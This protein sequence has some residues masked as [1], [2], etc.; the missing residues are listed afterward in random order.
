MKNSSLRFDRRWA[1]LGLL[2]LGAGLSYWQVWAGTGLILAAAVLLMW[3]GQTDTPELR[4]LDTLI[5][6]ISQGKLNH[7]LPRE[8]SDPLLESMRRNL[9]S[10]LDQTETAFREILGGM[11]AG[12]NHKSW[13]RLQTSGL[14]GIFVRVLTQMQGMLDD[15][16]QAQVSVAREALLS[17]IFVRSENGL[18]LA[19]RQVSSTLGEVSNQAS[20]SG[21][22]AN[23]FSSAALTMSS[24]AE[25]MSVALG[26]AESSAN[27]G[28]VAVT[29]LSE[30][31]EA[32]RRLTGN[33]DNIAKQTNLLALNASIEAARAGES[34]RGFAVVA[35]E[36]RKLADESQRSAEEIARAIDA[37][38]QSMGSAIERIG[39]LSGAVAS[40]RE[41][42]DEFGHELAA[43]AA[44]A[45]QVGSLTGH[46]VNGAEAMEAS[47]NVVAQAQKA[48]ADANHIIGG[49]ATG[50][51][52]LG[53]LETEA[54]R[55]ASDRRWIHDASERERLVALYDRLF[56]ELEGRIR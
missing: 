22:K 40:A 9:N 10:A 51:M 56:G 29:D 52:A 31:T 20:E 19:I 33:I 39:Q 4:Q 7:R 12:A 27:Q 18:S 47:M 55:I 45:G 43:S 8:F 15:L 24:A 25:R 53:E 16:Q 41:T 54:A 5:E 35:D 50:D 38:S 14:H 2:A 32:I 46:I 34:G 3:P 28:S 23:A 36:V 37:M 49:E 30:K 48:R 42:A 21:T 1:V 11:D 44:S 17:R 13:R 26:E 6:E